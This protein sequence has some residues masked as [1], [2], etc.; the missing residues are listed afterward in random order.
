MATP[1][2]PTA[3]QK[4]GKTHLEAAL[5]TCRDMPKDVMDDE[6]I[7]ADPEC[8]NTV[9]WVR[10]LQYEPCDRCGKPL[11]CWTC[12]VCDRN[13]ARRVCKACGFVKIIRGSGTAAAATGPA[14]VAETEGG[15]MMA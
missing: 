15:G 4:G 6:Q 9:M 12:M 8:Q 14:D 11:K 1:E 3:I 10:T 7:C 2:P 5:E 13:A